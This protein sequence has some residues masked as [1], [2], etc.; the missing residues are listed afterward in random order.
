MAMIGK[1]G[2]GKTMENPSELES[3]GIFGVQKLHIY[4]YIYITIC[5]YIPHI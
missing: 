3:S 1:T 2:V 5:V 4:I